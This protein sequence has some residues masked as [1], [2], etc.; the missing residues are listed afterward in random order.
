M[1]PNEEV[2]NSWKEVASYLGRGVRTVQR[3]EQELGLPVRRPRGRSRSAVIAFKS[4]LDKWLHNA[5]AEQL[6]NDHPDDRLPKWPQTKYTAYERQ[7]RLHDNTAVLISRT[8]VLL[9]RSQNLCERLN[10]LRDKVIK[11]VQLTAV[12]AT[13][14]GKGFL[15]APPLP[16]AEESKPRPDRPKSSGKS[17]AI[18]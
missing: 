15:D 2:L 12:H 13:H 6:Q 17:Q 11:T 9:E 16:P 10:T 5:P 1:G 14:N 7:T 8:H 3:W 4:E 18:A